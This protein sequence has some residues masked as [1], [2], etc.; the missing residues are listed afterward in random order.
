MHAIL[1][2]MFMLAAQQAPQQSLL[3]EVVP[4]PTGRNGYE[5]YLMACDVVRN[6]RV[7][8]ILTSPSELQAV[9]RDYEAPSQPGDESNE[10]LAKPSLERYQVARKYQEYSLLRLRR[11]AIQ[12]AGTALDLLA[13]GNKKQV[14][15]PR[16]QL[17]W[18]TL[19]P[20]LS[21]MRALARLA[22]AAAYVAY[23]DGQSARGNQYL[24]DIFELGH[25]LSRGV[26][27]ARLVGVSIHSIAFSTYERL[28]PAMTQNDA[29]KI[30]GAV[31]KWVSSPP[32]AVTCLA[33]E[34]TFIN[35]SLESMFDRVEDAERFIFS[36]RD[37]NAEKTASEFLQ[38]MTDADKRRVVQICREHLARQQERLVASY[39]RPESEWDL[40]V[41]EAEEFPES[42]AVRSA[43]DMGLYLAG[44]ISPAFSQIGSVEVR[45]RTQFRLL[46]LSAAVVR[47][48]W[49]HDMFPA[50]LPEA[51]GEENL[52]DPVS[53]D[54]FQYEV[55]GSGFKV[56][57]K[58]T[59]RT[60]EIGLRYVRPQ[61]GQDG[62]PPPS[63]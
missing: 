35:R 49:E 60:G 23:A 37:S 12:L 11:E 7:A 56:W 51:V 59:P 55:Q 2:S 20:E 32:A 9:V 22:S 34:F 48:K 3:R 45:N 6:T 46:R 18:D 41:D 10:K 61:Q 39:R 42:R 16:T 58:G 28:L 30:I 54:K 1:A 25:N 40:P 14:F 8:L 44:N 17:N 31:P 5:E 62:P 33:S 27:I 4:N 21:E 24:L 13:K 36:D 57:S 15:D 43:E 26:L 53:G 47:H 38:R 63:L 52:T 19:F 29:E 50:T